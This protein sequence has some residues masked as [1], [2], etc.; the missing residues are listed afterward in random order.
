MKDCKEGPENNRLVSL[1][2]MDHLVQDN[3]EMTHSQHGFVKS[4]SYLTDLIQ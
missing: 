2:V 1:K 3:Q 4:R